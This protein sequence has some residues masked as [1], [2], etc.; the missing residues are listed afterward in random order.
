MTDLR[1]ELYGDSK[2]LTLAGLRGRSAGVTMEVDGTIALEPEAGDTTVQI[3]VPRFQLTPDLLERLPERYV[4]GFKSLAPRGALQATASI[5][6]RGAGGAPFLASALI[7]LDNVSLATAPPLDRLTGTASFVADPEHP[8]S[9]AVSVNL[10]RARYAG[11]AVQDFSAHGTV[12]KELLD[13]DDADWSLYGGRVAGAI[14]MEL[15]TPLKY[16]GEFRISHLDLESLVAAMGET[17]DAPSGWLRGT[18]QFR[19]TGQKTAGLNL[20]GSCVVDRG[21]LYDLPLVTGV[22]NLLSL[23]LPDEGALSDAGADFRI[24]DGVIHVDQALLTGESIPLGITGT[25]Q[26]EPGVK[27]D[28]QKI[29]LLFTGE[30]RRGFLDRLPIIGWIKAVDGVDFRIEKGKT[31]GLVGESGCGKSTIGRLILRLLDPD[32][33]KILYGDQDISALSQQELKPLRKEMQI[34][35]Q[36]PFGSLNPRMSVGQSIEEGLRTLGVKSYSDRQTR[37]KELLEMVGLP[38]PPLIVIPTNSAGASGSAWG[39]QEP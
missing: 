16:S 22:W 6:A 31:L 11:L 39:S 4:S 28:E 1:G 34:I 18:V 5:V 2:A 20:R 15:G 3:R 23:Q 21:H 26:L 24:Q 35:F 27:F 33:G 12:S 36:D 32:N 17:E 30:R 7:A 38:L 19:G 10:S 13:I 9:G 29:N 37:V 8:G 25:I 14:R